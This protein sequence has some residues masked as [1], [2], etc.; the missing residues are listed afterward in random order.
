MLHVTPPVFVQPS[1][2]QAALA[3]LRE[4]SYV[5]LILQGAQNRDRV[6][7][8]RYIRFVVCKFLSDA[9]QV[10]LSSIEIRSTPGEAPIAFVEG[11]KLAISM[12]YDEDYA[13][14]AIHLQ[15]HIGIDLSVSLPD[16]DW[17]AVAAL[18][19]G[20]DLLLAIEKQSAQEGH[21]QQANI[22]LSYWLL[23]EA[24]LKCCGL[25]LQEWTQALETQ[26]A[27][28]QFLLVPT[29]QAPFIACA[30]GADL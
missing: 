16:F 3:F 19:L 11:K 5:I 14:A 10:P 30:I 1:Q 25:V 29:L 8:R 18:Y 9:F 7:A 21:K 27:T 17:G 6:Q 4:H 28:C 15:R 2:H 26:L 13:I 24:K 20:T 22:F 23:H 12:S